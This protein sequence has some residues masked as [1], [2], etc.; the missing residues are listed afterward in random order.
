MED[1]SLDRFQDVDAPS[2]DAD[3]GDATDEEPLKAT[4]ATGGDEAST[5]ASTE[6]A[7]TMVY[8]PAGEPCDRCGATVQRRWHTTAGQCCVDCKDW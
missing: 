6:T 7:P 8:T 2:D 3:Q 5:P 4:P 1:A